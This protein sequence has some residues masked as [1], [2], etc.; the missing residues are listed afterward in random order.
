MPSSGLATYERS[1]LKPVVRHLYDVERR[2]LNW[3][4]IRQRRLMT[5]LAPLITL[6]V[7]IVL[8]GTLWGLYGSR[9]QGDKKGPSWQLSGLIWLAIGILISLWSHRDIR[10]H[11]ANYQGTCA[12]ALRMNCAV[13][14]R[15]Q[16]DSVAIF[17]ARAKHA[18]AYAFQIGDNDIVV[19]VYKKAHPSSM[20]PN[21]DF[22]LV[23]LFTER[24]RVAVGLV[25]QRGKKIEPVRTIS[26]DVSPRL[27]V[28]EHLAVLR[29]RLSELEAL[30][31]KRSQ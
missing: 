27:R 29:G 13:E 25:E 19:I 17:E 3:G 22:S 9:H 24:K 8:F 5:R 2:I 16:S 31:A 1:V 30:L 12:S 11:A 23:D 26:S 20:F 7:G 14:I 28:P 10:R 6:A 21:A 18:T 4:I 15:I